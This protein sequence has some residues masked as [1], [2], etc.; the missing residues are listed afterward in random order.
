MLSPLAGL[1]LLLLASGSLLDGAASL[2]MLSLDVADQNC[3]L[4]M[5]SHGSLLP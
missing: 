3:S 5:T 2:P 4:L 1:L